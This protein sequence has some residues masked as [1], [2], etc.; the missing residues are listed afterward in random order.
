MTV[1]LN[2]L[3]QVEKALENIR[4]YLHADGGD[5]HIQHISDDGVVTVELMGNCSDCKIS[6]MT[7]KAGIE[8]A[9]VQ[10]VPGIRSVVALNKSDV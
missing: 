2:Q 7:L 10:A 6:H 4:P 5:V 8:Q 3:E 1:H 9:I